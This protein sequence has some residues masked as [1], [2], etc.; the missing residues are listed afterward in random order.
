MSRRHY[1]FAAMIVHWSLVLAA[2]LLEIWIALY[3]F[4][5]MRW[6]P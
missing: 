1:K 2:R 6:M 4:K 5:F 3:L